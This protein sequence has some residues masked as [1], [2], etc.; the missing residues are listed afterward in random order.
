MQLLIKLINLEFL[1]DILLLKFVNLLVK[2]R[3]LSLH[4]AVQRAY[5]LSDLVSVLAGFEHR[6]QVGVDLDFVHL[7]VLLNL[8]LVKDVLAVDRHAEGLLDDRTDHILQRLPILVVDDGL[9]GLLRVNEVLVKQRGF[10]LSHLRLQIF[11][12]EVLL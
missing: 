6:R 12:L 7:V 1:I 11:I 8:G 2:S 3:E 4:E 10:Y 9:H 5:G